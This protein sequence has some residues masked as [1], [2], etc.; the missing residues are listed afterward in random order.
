MRLEQEEKQE[1]QTITIIS[2]IAAKECRKHKRNLTD[3]S[4]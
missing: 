1:R 3:D 2:S 4:D